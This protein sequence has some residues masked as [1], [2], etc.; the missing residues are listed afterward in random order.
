DDQGEVPVFTDGDTN[1]DSLLDPDEVWTYEAEGTATTGQYTNLAT[2]TGTDPAGGTV[3]DE[4][5]SNYNGVT[6]GLPVT[7]IDSD[8]LG[9]IALL[10]L[11][12]GALLI[13]LTRSRK[14]NQDTA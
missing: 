6:E 1:G 7:G 8:V 11:A 13:V 14:R 12:A 4:D 5:P 3:T 10:L 9:I 2:V